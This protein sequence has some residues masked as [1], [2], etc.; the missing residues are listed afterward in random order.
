MW[1]FIAGLFIGAMIGFFV[2]ALLWAAGR[3]G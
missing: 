2:A 3:D 1:A